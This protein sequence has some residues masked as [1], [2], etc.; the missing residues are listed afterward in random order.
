MHCIAVLHGVAGALEE[1]IDINHIFALDGTSDK[2]S[3]S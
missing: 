2:S 3:G 1:G